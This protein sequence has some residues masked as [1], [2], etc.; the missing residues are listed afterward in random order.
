[1][2]ATLYEKNEPT[3]EPLRVETRPAVL[4]LLSVILWPYNIGDENI[5]GT[6]ICQSPIKS[7]WYAKKKREKSEEKKTRER[8]ENYGG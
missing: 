8:V 1:M 6:I 5:L 7:S 3:R 2:W 4:L